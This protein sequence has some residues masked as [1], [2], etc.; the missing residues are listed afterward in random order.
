[1]AD[2]PIIFA[3]AHPA[4]ATGFAACT[5]SSGSA[6][7]VAPLPPP[8]ASAP[9]HPPPLSKGLFPEPVSRAVDASRSF[10]VWLLLCE[11]PH[12]E[13]CASPQE[14]AQGGACRVGLRRSC[15]SSQDRGP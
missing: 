9:V 5:R 10:S 1:M 13:H 6:P 8:A 14:R 3:A 12:G 11:A 4:A 15:D 2:G 7:S